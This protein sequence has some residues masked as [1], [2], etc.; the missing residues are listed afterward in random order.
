LT[1][2]R[3]WYIG[4][5]Y[6]L[7]F[8]VDDGSIVEIKNIAQINNCEEPI[9]IDSWDFPGLEGHLYLI[10]KFNIIIS[11]DLIRQEVKV[12]DVEITYLKFP[13]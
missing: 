7:E 3:A 9:E 12:K 13:T 6:K 11:L 4:L 10:L 1:C 2:Q 8:Q 5:N